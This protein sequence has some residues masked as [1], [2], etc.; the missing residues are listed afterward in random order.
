MNTSGMMCRDKE[1]DW[2]KKKSDSR[3]TGFGSERRL[4]KQEE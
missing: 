1:E 3:G 4:G 2:G